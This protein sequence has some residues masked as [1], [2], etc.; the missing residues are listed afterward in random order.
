MR[1]IS[2][3]R[4]EKRILEKLIF[5]YN[6][7]KRIKCPA[8]EEEKLYLYEDG[9]IRCTVCSWMFKTP[10]RLNT[11]G[12]VWLMGWE[13]RNEDIMEEKQ[14]KEDPSISFY[15]SIVKRRRRRKDS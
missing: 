12:E 4:E 6:P 9:T 3:K 1:T 8:C 15:D 7:Q 13:L 10:L 14:I 2:V 11:N 5:K